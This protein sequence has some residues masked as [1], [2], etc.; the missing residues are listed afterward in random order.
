MSLILLIASFGMDVKR[1]SSLNL[2][3]TLSLVLVIAIIVPVV[4]VGFPGRE[5]AQ[6]RF[7]VIVRSE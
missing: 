6:Q 7:A 2:I 5:K 1:I 4:G 3:E